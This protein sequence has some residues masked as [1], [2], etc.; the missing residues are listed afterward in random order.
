MPNFAPGIDTAVLASLNRVGRARYMVEHQRRWIEWC[1]GNGFSY[2]GSRG[3][4]IRQA[5][6]NQLKL[7]EFKL[8]TLT[9]E[10][11]NAEGLH[12]QNI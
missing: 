7:Y 2:T 6:E 1:E 11:V 8:E 10:K 5:D 12:S 3:A 9:G 4:A